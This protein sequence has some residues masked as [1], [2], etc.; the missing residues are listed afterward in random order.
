MHKE[1]AAFLEPYKDRLVEL[2]KWE[3]NQEIPHERFGISV[4][5]DSWLEKT[6][7]L[8]EQLTQKIHDSKSDKKLLIEIAEYFIKDWGGIKR[9]SK[10]NEI[11]IRF[12]S[13]I[14]T[15]T[16][17]HHF[18]ASYKSISSWSKWVSLICPRWACIYDARVAYSLN[19]INY[20]CGNK[21]K[22]FPIPEGRNTKLRMLDI[23]T[24]LVASKIQPKESTHP[25]TLRKKYFIPESEAYREYLRT[26]KLANKEL[27]GNSGDIHDT[28]MLLFSIA[29]TYIYQD[30]FKYISYKN[31][32][33]AIYH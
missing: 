33:Y 20:L 2:Y 25:K 9:F 28:E 8:K 12:K 14:G 15:K 11:V 30:L 10:A 17:P 16:Q 1:I 26:I 6:R 22:I 31:T 7:N 21:H 32:P 5:G 3:F 13:I 23:T 19:A 24:L 4:S 29:D 18:D 27:W